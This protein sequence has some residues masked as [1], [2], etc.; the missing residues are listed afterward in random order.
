MPK[1]AAR[2]NLTD[3]GIAALKPMPGKRV[4]VFD[5]VVPGFAVRVTERGAKSFL[6]VTRFQGRQRWVTI[7]PVGAMRLAEAREAAREALA[8]VRRGIDPGAKPAAAS[9]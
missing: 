8:M 1:P 9:L 6:L 3:K 5:T 7:G 2:R 4:T